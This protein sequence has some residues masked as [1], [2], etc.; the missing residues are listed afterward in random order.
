MIRIRSFFCFLLL[1]ASLVAP[2]LGVRAQDQP[3]GAVPAAE[4]GASVRVWIFP[5]SEKEKVEVA[6]SAGEQS[7]KKVMAQTVAGESRSEEGY[8]P[9]A[10]GQ[11]QSELRVGERV[12]SSTPVSIR[13][14]GSY[15]LVVWSNGAKWESKLF[16]DA[17]AAQKSERHVRVV[18]FA[19]GRE[20]LLSIGGSKPSLVTGNTVAQ[21]PAPTGIALISVEVLDPKGGPPAL[22]SVE[23]DFS[24]FLNSYVVIAPDYRGRMRPRIIG[25][26]RTKQSLA[27]EAAAV[28][29]PQAP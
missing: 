27:A 16:L 23:I 3:P 19:D 20:A 5:G 14:G 9:V 1:G 29:A 12:V 10:E 4:R 7:E 24:T 22:S 11:L 26:G 13:K 2:P 21:F 28:A 6:F 17:G 15:T 8:Q 25:G 18:N